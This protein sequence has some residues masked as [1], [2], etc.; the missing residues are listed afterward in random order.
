M[1][2]SNIGLEIRMK[3]GYRIVQD[4]GKSNLVNIYSPKDRVIYNDRPGKKLSY[5]ELLSIMMEY[6][7]YQ[8]AL[9]ISPEVAD[10]DPE[11]DDE[12]HECYWCKWHRWTD[13]RCMQNVIGG[14][15]IPEMPACSMY[16]E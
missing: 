2:K 9:N 11:N 6:R 15:I 3:D 5:S 10:E 12:A 14:V 7:S 8:K 4:T 16:A 13:D 1:T